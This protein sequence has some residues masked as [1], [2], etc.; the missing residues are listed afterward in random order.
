[1]RHHV[2]WPGLIRRKEL[3]LMPY[4]VFWNNC[5]VFDSSGEATLLHRGDFVPAELDA[6]QVSNLATIGAVR[7]VDTALP[8]VAD[9]AVVAAAAALATDAEDPG[10]VEV[11]DTVVGTVGPGT[12]VL[13]G[14]D[15]S[16]DTG[17]DSRPNKSDSKAEWVEYAV[18]QGADR[19]EAEGTTKDDLIATYGG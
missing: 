10:E 18:S 12:T 13:E 6:V 11:V 7:F 5:N 4:Q 15:P 17:A 16:E 2:H 19:S 1:M 9:L 3:I 14:P 8:T